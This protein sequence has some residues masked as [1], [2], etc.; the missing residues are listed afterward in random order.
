MSMK[1]QKGDKVLITYLGNKYLLE[2]KDMVIGQINHYKVRILKSYIYNSYGEL[3]HYHT[4][5]E[6][7]GLI[8]VGRYKPKL[9]KNN[10]QLMMELL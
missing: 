5:L 1:Y 6:E 8:I 7:F 4:Y 10:D 9:I 2:I 3:K